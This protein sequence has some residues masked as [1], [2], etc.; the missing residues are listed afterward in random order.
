MTAK[1]EC[2]A[3]SNFHLLFLGLVKG[4]I[5]LRV[6]ALIIG[7]MIDGRGYNSLIDCQQAGDDFNGSR[8][9]E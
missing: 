2:I 3:Q 1:T 6:Q 9:A 4:E 8:G 7:E 5:E